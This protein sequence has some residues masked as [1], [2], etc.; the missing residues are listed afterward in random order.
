M[1]RNITALILIVISV[2]IYFT[3]GKDMIADAQAV[4][5]VNDRYT[6]ALS[7]A[8]RLVAVRDQ[9]LAEYNTISIEDRDRLDKMVPSTVDNIRL[10]LDLNNVAQRHGFTLSDV[11]AEASPIQTLTDGTVPV[12]GDIDGG[13]GIPTLDTV[14]VSFAADAPYDQFVSFLQDLESNLR[15]MDVTELSVLAN[16]NGTYTFEV[17]VQTYWVRQ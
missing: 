16:E 5:T 10:I 12:A 15:I 7:D 6:A 11:K 9:V 13:I 3:I 17:Q 8:E 14:T 2:G 4:K 1:N